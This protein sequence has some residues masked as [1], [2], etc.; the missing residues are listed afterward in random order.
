MLIILVRKILNNKWMV[1]S[2]LIGSILTVAMVSSVPIYTNGVLQRMLVK[3]LESYQQNY[4]GFP[5]RLSIKS[6]LH[7][8]S[9]DGNDRID[10][11][12]WFDNRVVKFPE[13][14]GVPVIVKNKS[15]IADNLLAIPEIQRE[16]KPKTRF[17]KF[18]GI[19][20]FEKHADIIHGRMFS[21]KMDG[22]II[23]AVITEKALDNL[24]LRLDE[25][26]LV[27][28]FLNEDKVLC[29]V[30]IV[31]TFTM[32][33]PGDLYWFDGLWNYDES[34]IIDYSLFNR[35][36]IET[37]KETEGAYLTEA[38]WNYGL[39]YHKIKIEHIDG[40][41]SAYQEQLRWI[42]KYTA[43]LETRLPLIPILEEYQKREKRLSITLWVLQVPILL[44][45][46]FYMFMVAQLIVKNE[47]NEIAVVKSRGSSSLQVFLSYFFE[48]LL[49]AG[50]AFLTG[51]PLG[52]FICR[53]LGLSNGF[54][55]FVQRTALPVELSKE[56]YIY[57]LIALALF[58][59]SMLLPAYLSSRTSIVL[60]KQ[61]KVRGRKTPVWKRYFLDLV[62]LAIAGYGLYN[63][64]M[65]KITQI[66]TGVSGTDLAIDPLLFLISTM[67]ILGAGLVF[68]RIYPLLVNLVFWVGKKVW[69]PALYA[70]FIHVG[71]SSGQEQFLMLFL[72]LALSL[73]IF[74][75]NA[76]RTLNRN[77]EE[78]VMYD[79]GAD[80]AIKAKWDTNKVSF[81][82]DMLGVG[83]M[84]ETGGGIGVGGDDG[85]V[86][87]IEP[88][89]EQFEKLSGVELATKVF[90]KSNIELRSI[91]GISY[92]VDLIGI[93]PDEF[94][95]VSWLRPGLL[96]YHW[97]NYL[98]L[99]AESP[100]A[101]LA[102]RSV[103][104][105]YKLREGDSIYITWE[106]QTYLEGYIY[107]FVDY[108]PTFNPNL[109]TPKGE[110]R[111]LIVA[112]FS[113]IQAKMSLEPY[114]VWIKRKPGATDTEVYND[115]QE[116][117][118]ELTD[119]KFTKNEI[120]KKKNDPMLQGTNG[121]LTMGFVITMLI[122][123]IGFLI[124]WVLSIRSRAL[125]FGI[126]RAMG[127]SMRNIVIMLIFE[128]LLISGM[129]VLMGIIIGGLTCD[130]FIP[131]IQIA[132]SVEE[133]AL[134]FKVFAYGG[135]YIKIYS[136]VGMMLLS[137]IT[138]LGILVSKININQAIKLGED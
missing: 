120:I 31:G 24:D 41:L 6:K 56:A 125:Q 8:Y 87:Y 119:I 135:D 80:I 136:I 103:Q 66:F 63:Y 115:I 91:A 53:I 107:A 73:G 89:F 116:K 104:E 97:Y 26:Y 69:T 35:F 40:I 10:A 70:S 133:L 76:A 68:L 108:W 79:V 3:D 130:L 16:E 9:N 34:F 22:D 57:S 74:N 129:A 29:K 113:Y 15:L 100:T 5:G 86:E 52:L 21:A 132:Y 37:G 45:L 27:K 126:F 131:L 90:R 48:S 7:Y 36:F 111:D 50:I 117:K 82:S 61:Q 58:I 75:A 83:M 46:A 43:I 122:S 128:Q 55:E 84:G 106:G 78:K 124:Y 110:P 99:L 67:F 25:V 88:P 60:Y 121:A 64:K 95:K 18:E 96:P 19:T 33:D 118:I 123:A 94:G 13:E 54:L 12:I 39:D 138:I 23:E 98:N 1:L 62:L 127:L 93:I 109:K 71:R 2:L 112:N 114:E 81:G 44:M 77:I 72:I 28:D 14:L 65:R 49:L 85:P 102:S 4:G 101:F 42:K 59:V 47:E 92:N 32:K 51:P 105:K 137:G 17:F 20:D 134:P 38:R 30:K 11:Y